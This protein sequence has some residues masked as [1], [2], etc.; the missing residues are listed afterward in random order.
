MFNTIYGEPI[1]EL[2]QCKE[3]RMNTKMAENVKIIV[4]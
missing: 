1:G 4:F 3:M 2:V